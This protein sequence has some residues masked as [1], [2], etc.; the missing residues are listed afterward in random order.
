MCV[1]SFN[2]YHIR[3]KAETNLEH[4]TTQTHI[5]VVI[6]AMMSSYVLSFLENSIVDL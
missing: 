4:K 3:I 2:I 5:P 6:R 1:V